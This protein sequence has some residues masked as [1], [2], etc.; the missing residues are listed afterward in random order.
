[1]EFEEEPD[2]EFIENML[3]TIK[4]KHKLGDTYEW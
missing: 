1:M 2:Y 3:T 4:E